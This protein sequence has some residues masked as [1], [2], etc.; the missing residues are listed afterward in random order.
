MA[1]EISKFFRQN[2][3]EMQILTLQQLAR[4]IAIREGST[5]RYLE[6]LNISL[7]ERAQYIVDQRKLNTS[8][9]NGGLK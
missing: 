8:N 4:Q 5:H 3:E 1:V 7:P 2:N 9:V 6:G